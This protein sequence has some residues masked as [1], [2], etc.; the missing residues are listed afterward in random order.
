MSIGFIF[1]LLMIIWAIFGLIWRWP[2][3]AARVGVYGPVGD[4]LLIFILF[5]LLGWRNFGFVIHQ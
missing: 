2:G 3:T 1:W 4:W 5:F